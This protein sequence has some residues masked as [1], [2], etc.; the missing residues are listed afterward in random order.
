MSKNALARTGRAITAVLVAIAM[1]CTGQSVV[2]HADVGNRDWLRPDNTGTC[3]WDASNYWVQRCDVYSP[4]MGKNITVLIQPAQRGGDAAFY[5][6][7]GMRAETD[8]TGW[9]NYASAQATYV[10]SNITLVMPLGGAGSFYTNWDSPAS[11][12]TARGTVYKWDT[13]LSVELPAY[14]QQNFGVNPTRNAI[15]GV[16]MGGTAALSLGARH[17]Q[18]FHQVLSYSGYAFTTFPGME[19]LI[20]LA[21]IDSGGYNLSSMYTS[22]FNPRRYAEDPFWNMDGLR[23]SDVY[24]AA[25][26]GIPMGGDFTRPINEI[27]MGIALEQTAFYT[28]ILWIAKARLSGIPFTMDLMPGGIHNWGI[29]T[30]QLNKTKARV[31]NYFN[32]W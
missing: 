6:L 21:L 24:V 13:F 1:I 23:G 20:R 28:T 16:S 8:F 9:V 7:D 5:L 32:A 29:W 14:L 15:G 27:V 22:L 17:P 30:E 31:L 3:E 19:T 11:F 10:D 12:S 18:Q 4:S 2:A 25:S 26:T